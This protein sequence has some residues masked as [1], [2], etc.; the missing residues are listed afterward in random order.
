[1]SARSSICGDREHYA[2]WFC[3]LSDQ[4]TSIVLRRA[5]C[6]VWTILVAGW[7]SGRMYESASIYVAYSSVEEKVNAIQKA[8][9]YSACIR[10]L[11]SFI[12]C[13]VMLWAVCVQ[14]RTNGTGVSTFP[15]SFA[16]ARNAG[17]LAPRRGR[18][19]TSP[20][21]DGT[22]GLARVS[23]FGVF[24]F[25]CAFICEISPVFILFH[26]FV[27][28]NV[29]VEAKAKKNERDVRTVFFNLFILVWSAR[30][31]VK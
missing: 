18:R 9:N 20:S 30:L 13:S 12:L 7:R 11:I 22:S 14:C 28:Q 6:P 27:P 31:G 29:A 1:M 2:R 21:L 23:F 10:I 16:T 26:R 5:R 4:W 17:P 8:L 24:P 25:S 3:L 19:P 15:L